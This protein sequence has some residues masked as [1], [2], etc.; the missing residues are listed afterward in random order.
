MQLLLYYTTTVLYCS[1]RV[2]LRLLLRCCSA[3]LLRGRGGLLTVQYCCGLLGLATMGTR[4]YGFDFMKASHHEQR[5]PAGGACI[6]FVLSGLRVKV[7]DVRVAIRT[8]SS[9]EGS[10]MKGKLSALVC[11]LWCRFRC[12]TRVGMRGEA[13]SLRHNVGQYCINEKHQLCIRR[14]ELR[15]PPY[16]ELSTITPSIRVAGLT[17]FRPGVSAWTCE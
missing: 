4:D 7:A 17:S 15:T 3:V 1:S 12:P 9:E 8:E 6:V 11:C 14:R 16:R 13:P 5:L 2:V 10:Y